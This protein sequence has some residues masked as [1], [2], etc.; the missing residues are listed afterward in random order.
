MAVTLDVAGVRGALRLGDSAEE[1]A[2]ATRLLA[3]ATEAISR[4]LGDAYADTP[5]VIVNE[6]ALRL[7]AFLYDQ[8]NAGRGVAYANAMRS[9]GAGAILLPYRIHRAGSTAEAVAAAQEA[10]GSPGNPVIDVSVSLADGTLTVTFADGTTRVESLPAGG[11]GGVD[12]AARDAAA[13]NTAK[14]MPP[15][16]AE[17]AN[18]QSTTIRGWTAGLIR[19]LVEAVVPLWARDAVTVVPP[20]K[21][22]GTIRGHRVF[23][24]D[25]APTSGLDGDVWIKNAT[26]SH[27]ALY[28]HNG[29]AFQLD[30]SFFG[31]RVHY[32][33][34]PVNVALDT[35]N[36]NR[37]DLL[38]ELVAG[39]LKIYRRVTSSPYWVSI[40]TVTG[41]GG[42]GGINV[43]DAIASIVE[44]FALLGNSIEIPTGKFPFSIPAW[45][46]SPLTHDIPWTLLDSTLHRWTEAIN[47][48]VIDDDKLPVIR[49]VPDPTGVPDG[50]IAKVLGGVWTLADDA[51]G[52]SGG[53]VTA[54]EYVRIAAPMSYGTDNTALLNATDWRDYEWLTVVFKRTQDSV[55]YPLH[56]LT[57][58]LDR[59][60]DIQVPIEQNAKIDVYATAGS[61]SLTLGNLSGITGSPADSDTVEIWGYKPPFRTTGA[62]GGLSA[63]GITGLTAASNDEVHTN[64]IFPGVFGGVLRKFSFQNLINLVRSTVGLG[65][66]INPTGSTDNVGKVPVLR[67]DGSDFHYELAN[68]VTLP[69]IASNAPTNPDQMHA[70]ILYK[71]TAEGETANEIY[72]KRKHDRESVII[73]FN[74]TSPRSFGTDYRS[75]GWT[76][77][78]IPDVAEPVPGTSPYPSRP[79]HWNA[80]IR[81]Q[82]IASGLYEWRLYADAA[83]TG[84]ATIYLDMRSADDPDTFIQNAPLTKV[85]GESYWSGGTHTQA[86]FPFRVIASR[87]LRPHIRLRSADDTLS[88][89]IIHLIEVDDVREAIV[90]E[91]RL[92][93]AY[94]DILDLMAARF[95]Q[96]GLPDGG[97]TGDILFRQ[98]GSTGWAS[99]A[100]A[101]GSLGLADSILGS[102]TVSMT[103]AAIWYATGVTLPTDKRWLYLSVGPHTETG[104]GATSYY[105]ANPWARVLIADMLLLPDGINGGAATDQS[106][107]SAASVNA[108][109]SEVAELQSFRDVLV[110]VT[111]ANELLVG[112]PHLNV[113]KT[114]SGP[115]RFRVS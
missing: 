105:G 38:F 62:G 69:S 88:T 47:T 50:Q 64:A 75:F 80:F 89:S 115:I 58:T 37:G 15:S 81:V 26:T 63:A 110:G 70:G 55:D 49:F 91:D 36:A 23:V 92:H 35:P 7:A 72:Y 73:A 18:A 94:A 45:L 53:D 77:H 27:P 2:E 19:T 102:A 74:D 12:Q 71:D 17:A 113:G 67:E 107:V 65:R 6:G 99:F 33:T 103:Q 25:T 96:S 56:I 78:I 29:I 42:G 84:F 3:Y 104:G 109:N 95:A 13:S 87:G 66:Q 4:H 100:M 14:L 51:Q 39:T 82:G 114:L 76:A 24:Q 32:Q 61:D 20:A 79:M 21:I 10:M 83:F 1:T 34:T 5:A 9:S 57:H 106:T 16:P 108:I 60:H 86:D 46:A 48:D 59:E 68:P 30:F 54:A 41:G 31:G 97:N 111:D 43:Q 22:S 112:V 11:G 8:P 44:P 52:E 98:S 28:G 101:V 85:A 90:D 93:S 40:G